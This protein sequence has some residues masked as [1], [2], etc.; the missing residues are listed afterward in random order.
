MPRDARLLNEAL[1]LAPRLVAREPVQIDLSL[2]VELARD[3]ITVNVQLW[4]ERWLG[5]LVAAPDGE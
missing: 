2:R 4:A 3:G 5:R 1:E